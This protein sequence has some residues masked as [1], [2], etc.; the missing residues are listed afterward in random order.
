MHVFT[1]NV[2]GSSDLKVPL[3]TPVD[4]DGVKVWYFPSKHFRR[5]YGSPSMRTALITQVRSFDL[6]HLHSV[7]L[8]PTWAAARTAERTEV[9]YIVAPRGMLVKELIHKKSRWIKSAWIRFI[10]RHTLENAT[11]IHVT[12]ELEA[13]ELKRFGFNLPSVFIVPNGV[14]YEA[15]IYLE[16]EPSLL[17][18]GIAG[19]I[20]FLL[21]LGRINWKKGLDRLIPALTY[22]PDIPLIIAGNDE[23]NYQPVLEK[24]AETH[25][26]RDRILFVGS[27]QDSDKVAL[28]KNAA[29]LILPSYSENFGN[30]ILEAMAAGCPVVVTPEV[31]LANIVKQTGAGLVIEGK[32]SVLGES[33]KNLLSDPERL[34]YLGEQG[35]KAVAVNFTW[36]SVGKQMENVYRTILK[37]SPL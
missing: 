19:K 35:Q 10:E 36:N 29:A 18:K 20:P 3:E 15:S 28:L 11:G 12:T 16:V 24:L 23:E 7:Y 5:L 22:V 21:F 31:G 37:S 6:L 1:T 27:V 14:D 13:E 32:P 4:R 2:D 9:P 25:R 17:V 30:V 8:W 33:L 26:V 34:R